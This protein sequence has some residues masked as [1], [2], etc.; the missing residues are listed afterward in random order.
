[1]GRSRQRLGRGEVDP[2][3]RRVIA[4]II[5]RLADLGERRRDRPS[6]LAD[7]Q[8]HQSVAVPLVKLGGTFERGGAFLGRGVGPWRGGPR[9]G[10]EGGFDGGFVGDRGGADLPAVV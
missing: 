2:R 1:A 7:D 10:G 5:G 9:G 8:R 3:P 4:Q 6:A